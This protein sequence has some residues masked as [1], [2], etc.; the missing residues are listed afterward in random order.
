MLL[1]NLLFTL[2][3]NK[4]GAIFPRKG[5]NANAMSKK[6]KTIIAVVAVVLV[7][8]IAA[9]IFLISRA[10]SNSTPL[11]VGYSNFSSK[12]SPFFATTA[13]DQ[14]VASMT[15]IS[16]LTTD[17]LGGVIYNAIEGETVEYNGTD[18]TYTGPADVKVTENEDGTVYY[19]ITIRDDLKFSDGQK[20]TIDDLIFSYYVLADPSYDGSSSLY[21]L[22]I[23]GMAEYRGGMELLASLIVKAG[24]DNTDFSLWDEEA[25]K[26]FWENSDK[27]GV[28]MCQ[29]IVD[30]CKGAGYNAED[31][32]VAAC[33][34]NWGFELDE[35]ATVEDF[36]ATVSEAYGDDP[37]EAFSVESAGSTIDMLMEGYE[38]YAKAIK[39]GETADN[40][41]G[42]QKTGD[43]SMR[44]V[45]TQLDASMIYQLGINI[46][47]L[48]YYGDT[49][50]YD[51]ENNKFG[52]E[53]GDL[54][55]VR[56]VTT[57]PLGAGP[58]IFKSFENGVVSF[59]ANN[60]YFKG[61]PKTKY[62]NF[63]ESNDNDKL[64]GVITGTIDI[65]DPSY[66]KDTVDAITKAN[67]GEGVTGSVITTNTVDNLGY[68]Y[69]GINSKN[70]SVG[71]DAGSEASK[72]LRKGIATILSVYRDVSID[73]YYADAASVINYPISNTSW[74]AP[75]STDD[76]YKVA[77][78]VDVNGN[79]I[80]TS[81]MTAEERYAAAKEAAL[82]YFEA[83]GYTVENGKVTAAPEGAKMEY[84]ALV[85]GDGTG[86]HPCFMLLSLAHDAFEEIGINFIV[87]D[88]SN[89][90]D[91]WNGLDAGTVEIWAAAWG[92]TIDPDL[93][94]VYYSDAA[95]GGANPGGS[96]SYY[97][98]TDPEL[99]QLILDSRAS[100]DQ[101][102]RKA[103]L[104]SALDII[105]DW[106]DEIPVYQ[107][108]NAIIFS[109]QRVNIDSI[110]PDITTFYG[111]MSEIEN[112]TLK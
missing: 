92:A 53:K 100:T 17:R 10:G 101:Q 25:Q 4:E 56:S 87:T 103:V 26:T 91:L 90:T 41:T 34:A 31:D 81:D 58:Y 18:Y 2:N 104:K 107:R 52:F 63:L 50:L 68:G 43:Y 22:P 59:E 6:K 105:V 21:S 42:I 110:T 66:S 86:N 74:A 32:S 73:S 3:Y 82:G 61:A 94:Q 20:V 35:S 54:S 112:I 80:Y 84:E 16:V 75:Q 12:F 83:A 111:W 89:S 64:N 14:D 36:W 13:Y 78:S 88:L 19:D 57:K 23:E 9:G 60:S 55:K 38:N 67:D 98:I 5:N 95:N 77:F 108:Q 11:V 15:Q 65:T 37:L 97:Q 28:A 93:F 71:G 72:N 48:H 40:I 51:Y 46:S 109:T 45:S 102:Y 69:I 39:T 7:L 85:P 33:A 76:G 99:D 1:L 8:A 24:R 96:W 44:I 49:S 29:E 30:Y 27:A 79:D 106:A 47:P 70:V 62:I